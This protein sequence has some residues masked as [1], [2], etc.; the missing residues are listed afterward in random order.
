MKTLPTILAVDDEPKARNLLRNLLEIEGYRVLLAEDGPAALLAAREQPDA[1]LLDLMMPGMDG[2]EVCRRLR[3]DAKLADVPIIMLTALDDRASRLEGLEAGADD[4]LCKPFDSAELRARLRTITR[5]NRFRRLSEERARF[6]AAID[7]APEGIVLAELDGTILHANAAFNTLLGSP[8]SRPANFFA[9]LPPE[10]IAGIRLTLSGPDTGRPAPRECALWSSLQP[11]P[12]V[13]ITHGLVPWEGRTIVQFHLRDLTER[14]QL[15]VQLLR[16]Q[17]IELL[18]QLAGSVVHDMNNVLTAVGGSAS[19]IEMGCATPAVHLQNIH[20]SVQRGGAM[21]RQL[22]MFAR[23]SDGELET[24]GIGGTIAEVTDLVRETFGRQYRVS[25]SAT[26]DL[27]AV[28]AD[29]TQIHQVVM[30]LCVNAR[31]AMPEGGTLELSVHARTVDAAAAAGAGP[32][33]KPGEYVAVS[34]RDTGTGIPPEILPK[35]FDP[36]FTTKPAGK[37]TGL[38]LATVMRVMRRHK[39]FVTIDTAVGKGTCFTCHFPV[40]AAPTPLFV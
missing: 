3:A 19:L 35:L 32:D 11:A 10:A 18:G 9:C 20:K 25:F 29:P 34:V 30:N 31:D 16:S 22:L 12:V 8:A 23:G 33:V 37:G 40:A 39:G 24:G 28:E 2:F 36:F 14:K 6:E 5:L 13:E 17:R 7:Y 4:F 38:G 1:V 15:E 26:D 27:P 21:M